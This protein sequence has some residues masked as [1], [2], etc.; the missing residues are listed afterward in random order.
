M[1]ENEEE[2]WDLINKFNVNKLSYRYDKKGKVL[3][4]VGSINKFMFSYT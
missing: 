3:I 1:I 2:I 4:E